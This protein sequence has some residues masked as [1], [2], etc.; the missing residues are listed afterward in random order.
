MVFEQVFCNC[1]IQ[2]FVDIPSLGGIDLEHH[3]SFADAVSARQKRLAGEYI[4]AGI[5]FIHRW[6]ILGL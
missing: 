4:D 6:E 2:L 1:K 5:L 3:G